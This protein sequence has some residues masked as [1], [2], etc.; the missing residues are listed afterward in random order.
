MMMRRHGRGG[1]VDLGA[2]EAEGRVEEPSLAAV[3]ERVPGVRVVVA[4]RAR[5]AGAERETS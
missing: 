3:D 1:A 5:A 2:V 4:V